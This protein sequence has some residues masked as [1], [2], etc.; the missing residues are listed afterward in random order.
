MRDDCSTVR[1]CSKD[2]KKI[3][4]ICFIIVNMYVTSTGENPE[5]RGAMGGKLV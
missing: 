5:E 4:V 3:F 2:L 1:V